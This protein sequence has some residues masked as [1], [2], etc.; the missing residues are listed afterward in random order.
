MD[1]NVA[2][3]TV[4]VLAL[5]CHLISIALAIYRVTRPASAVPPMEAV[6]I[7]RPVCGVD[8][9]DRVTLETSFRLDH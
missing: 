6:S 4:I 5:S 7:L 2:V 9:Y 8:L 1:Y 3:A